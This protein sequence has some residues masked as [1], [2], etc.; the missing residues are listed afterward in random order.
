MPPRR[1]A[2][3]PPAKIHLIPVEIF[4]EIFRFAI[5]VNS[6]SQRNLMLVCRRWHDIML[7]T[8]G[9]RSQLRIG[10]STKKKEVEAIIHGN[11]SLLDVT[12]DMNIKRYGQRFDAR[13][14]H[15]CLMAAAQAASRWR[16]F[17]LVSPPPRGEYEDLQILQP[18]Q[19]LE[20]FTLHQGCSLG[21]FLEPL[22]DAIAATATPLLTEIWVADPG[23]VVYLG[24]LACMHVFQSLRVLKIELSKKMDVPVNILPYL[25]RL[26][27][28]KAH[29]ICLPIFP[30]NTY[31]PLTR[32]LYSLHLKCVSIQWMTEQVFPHL[33]ECAIIFPR[34]ADTI[35]SVNLPSCSWFQYD[36]NNLGTLRHFKIPQ[37]A[38]L[39]VKCGQ[40][41]SWRG[42]LQ[43]MALYPIFS[44]AQSLT[45]LYLQVQCSEKILVYMLRLVTSLEKLVLVLSF[46]MLSA[47]LSS[48]HLLPEGLVQ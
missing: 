48:S 38:S 32:T 19:H 36:S 27:Y 45:R 26:E 30:P 47:R 31:L 6:R 18:L 40:W 15:A 29:H 35:R 14:F 9:N 2:V 28:F 7:S 22:V 39:G 24:Q 16:S 3:L 17:E 34:R 46:P 4:S 33:G 5:L 25:E 42:N 41:S 23:A 1:R 44:T 10:R 13:K 8:P 11:R 20:T 12:I 43:L 21:N 37:I